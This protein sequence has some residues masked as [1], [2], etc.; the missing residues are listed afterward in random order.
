MID[1]LLATDFDG[2]VAGIVDDPGAA[3]LDGDAKR[4]LA[5]ATRSPRISVALVSGR[6]VE[7][8][9]SRSELSGVWL[10]GSHGREIR[11][12]DGSW[13]ARAEPVTERPDDELLHALRSSGFRIEEK[14]FGLAIHWRE[15]PSIP[16]DHPAIR[17]FD[18]WA[19]SAGLEVITG[20]R[21]AEARSAGADKQEALQRIAAELEPARVVYAGD[22][23]TDFG[24][25]RWAATRGRGVFVTSDEREGPGRDVEQ[26]GSRA[27]LL[28][29]F[30]SEIRTVGE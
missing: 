12:P 13:L 20:R 6:D 18:S 27:E 21:V 5:R 29:I 3:T 22:D 7:D 19:R 14:K 2:T 28:A 25:L 15:R 10:A 9:D 11:R 4:V 23:L 1:L 17:S 24:A 16:D 8:L 30:E 26:A